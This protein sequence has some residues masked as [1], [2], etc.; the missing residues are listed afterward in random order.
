M[1]INNICC[2]GAGYVGGPTMAVIE[3]LTCDSR[4]NQEEIFGPVT[5]L[6]SFCTEEDAIQQANDTQ[7]GLSASIWSQNIQRC[8]RVAKQ[9]EA[10]VVWVNAWMLR[11]LRIP[12][13]G[14]HHSGLGR[15]GGFESLKF[16]TET[17]N[18]CIKY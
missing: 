1:K 8:H 18:V 7:Y 5:T 3:G 14:Y 11:D 10:G 4:I 12:F 15:E 9:I 2:I 17:K 6:Q 16:F 13:G